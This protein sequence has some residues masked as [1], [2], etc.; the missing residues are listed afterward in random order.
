MIS[1]ISSTVACNV[2]D[3]IPWIW[4]CMSDLQRVQQ[5]PYFLSYPIIIH[6]TFVLSLAAPSSFPDDELRVRLP[7][8]TKFSVGINA[9]ID[10][11]SAMITALREAPR[12]RELEFFRESPSSCLHALKQTLNVEVLTVYLSRE[13]PRALALLLPDRVTLHHLHTLKF[14]C[15]GKGRLLERL[16]LPALQT[17]HL[18]CLCGSGILWFINLGIQTVWPLR[19]IYLT[20]MS[21]DDCISCLRSL[22]SITHVEI[23]S[24]LLTDL[25]KLLYFLH[26]DRMALPA[27]ETRSSGLPPRVFGTAVAGNACI[28]IEWGPSR[29]SQVEVFPTWICAESRA[30]SKEFVEEI[31]AEPRAVMGAGLE[32]SID[33]A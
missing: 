25:D 27:L 5:G 28:E 14:N 21:V 20:T 12:L 26:K 17:I 31:W 16:V 2:L 10:D 30:P 19:S 23:C 32:V 22:P 29:R 3:T 18:S 24:R 9:N 15:D 33:V 8:L 1:F 7:L 6:S 13:L 4:M 11:T